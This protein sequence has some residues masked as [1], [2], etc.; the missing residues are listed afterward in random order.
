MFKKLMI[1]TLVAL[2]VTASGMSATSAL[3]SPATATQSLTD[4]DNAGL[5]YMYE[6]EKLA[7]NVY[8]SLYILWGQPTFQNIAASEQTHMDAIRTLLVRY[9]IAVPENAAGV[10]NDASLQTLYTN[11]MTTGSLSL[12]DA[13][14]VGAT[15][16]EVDITDLQ[17]RLAQTTN[18]DIQL[19]YNNLMKGSYNH[20]RNFVNVLNRLTGEVYQP[21]Y[22]STDLYQS[23][24]TNTNGNGHGQG[25]TTSTTTTGRGN[26][27]GTCV[28]T[29]TT[30]S[31]RGYR[32]GR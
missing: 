23:I 24:V 7:H 18:T 29:N 17:S 22:L 16:E 9:G 6:E 28:T 11:L 26:G 15:I 25:G 3:A 10:F 21:Q 27:G 1:G 13:L 5:L 8:S 4:N 30:R 14:R 20:L 31:S 2:F 12:A 19:V 32:G